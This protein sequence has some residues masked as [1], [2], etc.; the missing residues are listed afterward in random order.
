MPEL[1][2]ACVNSPSVVLYIGAEEDE[3]SLQAAIALY[4]ACGYREASQ[5][6]RVSDIP[7]AG[8]LLLGEREPSPIECTR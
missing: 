1:C 4:K 3:M 7:T 5:E 2:P 8:G 6:K